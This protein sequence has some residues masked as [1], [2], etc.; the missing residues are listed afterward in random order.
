MSLDALWL[1]GSHARADGTNASDVDLLAVTHNEKTRHVC[2]SNLSLF[3]YPWSILQ[4]DARNGGLFVCHLALEAKSLFDPDDYLSS[5]KDAFKYRSDYSTEIAHATD[6]GWYLVRHGKRMDS[7]L[8]ARRALWSIRTILIARGA[9][10]REPLFAPLLL[11]EQTQSI[12]GGELLR[13]RHCKRSN[14]EIRRSLRLFLEEETPLRSS[15]KLLERG[16]F[17]ER[18]RSTSNGVAMS[19]LQ[20]QEPRI[21]PQYC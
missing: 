12:A 4:D 16:D 14:S 10:Q 13:N 18:F 6:L 21:S 9:E 11:A 2:E 1:F 20:Q 5:L 3:L 19:T 8:L 15:S 17:I 7:G